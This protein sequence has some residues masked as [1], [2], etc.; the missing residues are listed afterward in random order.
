MSDEPRE[1]GMLLE[2]RTLEGERIE[3]RFGG[4]RYR[5]VCNTPYAL[6][7]QRGEGYPRRGDRDE[8]DY[9]DDREYRAYR[10]NL[11]ARD[12]RVEAPRKQRVAEVQREQRDLDVWLQFAGKTASLERRCVLA[13]LDGGAGICPRAPAAEEE[14]EAVFPASQTVAW[15]KVEVRPA[16]APPPR[17]AVEAVPEPFYYDAAGAVHV[18]EPAG[19]AEPEED[20]GN[21]VALSVTA[22]F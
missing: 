3:Q 1:R 7:L 13:A 20:E 6:Q 4:D 15:L 11:D 2:G 5:V 9:R 12:L 10:D 16:P 8:R 21:Y 17:P 14:N 22:R 19:P 18:L